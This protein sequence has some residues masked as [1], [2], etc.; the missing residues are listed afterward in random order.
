MEWQRAVTGIALKK[1]EAT[2]SVVGV[3]NQPGIAATLFS[4]LGD[5]NVNIDMIIQSNEQQNTT[6]TITFTVSEDDF[7][8]AKAITETVA[9]TLGADRVV[10][11]TS[12]AKLS[13]VGVGMISKPGVAATMFRALAH[14]GINIRLITTSDIK[15]S[16][17]I[18]MA[19]GEA[20][21]K[22]LHEA[23]DLA[24]ANA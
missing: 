19:V 21:L 20:A 22:A 17:A 23:F 11:D 15:I 12:I 9:K 6:N 8:E 14:A 5:H 1:D 18:D 24:A 7:L 4:A 2:L 16:C 13:I 3:P 10:G